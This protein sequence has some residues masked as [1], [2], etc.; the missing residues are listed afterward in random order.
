MCVSRERERGAA[1]GA[2]RK[3]LQRHHPKRVCMAFKVGLLLKSNILS[4]PSRVFR[5]PYE[6]CAVCSSVHS[7][8]TYTSA[9]Q[10]PARL[11]GRLS[12]SFAVLLNS[13][14]PTRF[15]EQKVA[16]SFSL[17]IYS[18]RAAQRRSPT[19]RPLFGL[20]VCALSFAIVYAFRSGKMIR[21]FH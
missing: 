19:C 13:C 1:Q 15:R 6:I 5:D 10:P 17:P 16:R 14:R 20:F 11:F 12:L 8:S 9:A 21:I 18:V 2:A 7:T 3:T 4:I